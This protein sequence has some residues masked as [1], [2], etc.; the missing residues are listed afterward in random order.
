MLL[1]WWHATAAILYS[2]QNFT[3]SQYS[4]FNSGVAEE[5]SEQAVLLCSEPSAFDLSVPRL[6]CYHQGQ[7]HDEG[8]LNQNMM[9]LLYLESVCQSYIFCMTN[10]KKLSL[11]VYYYQ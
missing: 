5:I 9:F 7:G 8:S 2:Y 3:G 1:N 10:S 6:F 4:S 11:S